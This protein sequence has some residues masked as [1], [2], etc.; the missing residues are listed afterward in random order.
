MKITDEDYPRIIIARKKDSSKLYGPFVSGTERNFLMKYLIRMFSLRTCKRLPKR[1]CLRFH[2]GLC[3]A[4]CNNSISKKEYQDQIQKVKQI[5]TGNLNQTL[6]DMK[7]EMKIHAKNK[8]F[9]KALELRNR[10]NAIDHL[11]EKQSVER[12]KNYD[13]DVI[14]FK[15]KEN[16]VYLMLFNVYKG[17]LAS[18]NEFTFDYIENWLEDFISQYYSENNIPKEIILPK[19]LDP[20][21]VEFLEKK[22]K[23]R[24]IMTI[25]KIGEKKSLL[26]LVEKNI[27]VHFF[28]NIKKLEELKNKL[29]LQDIPNIIECFDISH[30]AGTNTV[31]SM[32]QFRNGIKDKSNYR[33]FKIRSTEGIDDFKS[34]AEVVR[35][36]YKRLVSENADLPDLIIID[37][38]KGQLT[39][40]LTELKKLELKIPIISLAK[41]FEEIFVPGLSF[42]IIINKK[43]ASLKFLQEIRDEAHRFAIT[44]NKLLRKK[45][46]LKNI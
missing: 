18:K 25:P 32:V 21:L 41:K 7:K 29:K 33:R 8:E 46:L 42:P 40:G 9:E 36:R 13:E 12:Q 5:L 38:G 30:L 15:I 34:I 22:R 26:D 44:Y 39:A 23:S 17:T 37:G 16:K 10:L 11:K 43:E 19:K 45:E 24:I 31:A 3:K 2:I 35:R 28:G 6:T 27:E 1:P 4:P 14:N 20:S